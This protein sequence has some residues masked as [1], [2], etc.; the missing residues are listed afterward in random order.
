MPFDIE[1]ARKA[2]YSDAEIADHLAQSS[3]FDIASARKAGYSDSEILQHLSQPAQ[4]SEKGLL[5]KAGEYVVNAANQYAQDKIDQSAGMS[6]MK[7][8]GLGAKASLVGTGQGIRQLVSDSAN[9]L[10]QASESSPIGNAVIN[11]IPIVRDINRVA[12]MAGIN[13]PEYQQQL[14]NEIATTAQENKPILDTT[15]GKVGY[16]GGTIA[17]AIPTAFIP[18]VNTYTGAAAVGGALGAL[19]PVQDGESRAK[20]IA[21]GIGTGI[22]GQGAGKAI[23]Y[24]GGKAIDALKSMRSS[25]APVADSVA[26][27]V[28][29]SVS[30]SAS[31]SLPDVTAEQAN[32]L[33]FKFNTPLKEAVKQKIESGNLDRSTAQYIVNGA[34]KVVSD[35]VAKDVIKQGYDDGLVAMIKGS[36]PED[37]AVMTKMLDTLEKSKQDARFSA[38]NR[39]ADHVGDSL[40]ERYRQVKAI[41]SQAVSKLDE[42]AKS[43]K[44]KPFDGSQIGNEFTAKLESNL[45][46]KIGQDGKLDFSESTIGDIP[47]AKIFITKIYNKMRSYKQLDGYAAH[48]FKKYIDENVNWGKAGQGLTGKTEGFV[49]QLR[50]M[51]DSQLD[52]SFPEYNAVNTQYADSINAMNNFSDV[53]G[54]FFNDM[55]PNASKQ[56]GTLSRRL[57]SNVQSR[58]ALLDSITGL[59]NVAAKYGKAQKGDIITQ[60]LFADELDRMFG[61][62]AKTS[63][64]GDVQKAAER[65]TQA[66]TG[67]YGKVDLIKDV[68]GKA[69]SAARGVN[70]QAAIKSMRELL[71]R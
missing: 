46:V 44:D 11:A 47:K 23:G 32:S 28:A 57:M 55:S 62:S 7:L 31:K 20:N 22:A 9:V 29:E 69:V 49:K 1:G 26:P 8:A 40:A 18:G 13:T 37:K 60:A 67:G 27:S 61:A 17:Q 35:P 45:G 68:A 25:V 39:P 58:G 14:Q 24:V 3:K 19:Q 53:A 43:L 10:R 64:Q 41:N 30:N 12:G 33:L 65:A 54:S 6:D 48:N 52:T 38:L 34:G 66:V 56:L 50:G 2:G 70:E 21:V 71:K 51:I 63:L 16:I 42:V 59:E 4:P 15:A 5:D 36:A